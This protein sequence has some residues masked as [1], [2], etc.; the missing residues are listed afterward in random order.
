MTPKLW[1]NK[2]ILIIKKQSYFDTKAEHWIKVIA[3]NLIVLSFRVIW[4]KDDIAYGFETN[5]SGLISSI[6][7]NSMGLWLISC[8]DLIVI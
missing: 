5:L 6:K 4:Y 1:L 3:T 8:N 7:W 2:Q